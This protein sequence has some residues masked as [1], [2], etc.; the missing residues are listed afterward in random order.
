MKRL[1][2]VDPTVKLDAYSKYNRSRSYQ[3]TMCREWTRSLTDGYGRMRNGSGKN[4]V[5]AH[6]V[7]W[8]AWVGPIPKGKQ[9]LHRCDNR[10]CV[11]IQHLFLGDNTTNVKDKVSKGRQARGPTHSTMQRGAAGPGAKLK[12]RYVDQIRR[13]TSRQR[14]VAAVYG[15]SQAQ[16]SRIKNFVCW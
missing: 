14:D 15:I 16:V 2:N 12:Q 1:R 10:R 13:S 7:A 6:R 9:V 8:E 4:M 11:N 3:G 5:L